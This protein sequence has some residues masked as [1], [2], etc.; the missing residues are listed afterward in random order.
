MVFGSDE[1]MIHFLSEKIQQFYDRINEIEQA[2]QMLEFF[3]DQ[4]DKLKQIEREN[5]IDL[6]QPRQLAHAKQ[7]L[8]Q[9]RLQ[10]FEYG[11]IDNVCEL[12]NER[13]QELITDKDKLAA[14]L[15]QMIQRYR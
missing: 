4:F 10:L 5:K 8:E 15:E 12:R 2:L 1:E 14:Q 7:E 11:L 9:L 6:I 3:K 13:I